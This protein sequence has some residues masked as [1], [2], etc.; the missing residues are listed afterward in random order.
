M[1]RCLP[2]STR[3]A[4]TTMRFSTTISG[5]LLRTS[6]SRHGGTSAL[7]TTI[8]TRNVHNSEGGC[9]SR[10]LLGARQ[11]NWRIRA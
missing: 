10:G 4:G 1:L 6:K 9:M 2:S 3:F 8:V 11:S 5:V 7:G